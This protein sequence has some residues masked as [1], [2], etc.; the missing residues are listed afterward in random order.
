[1]NTQKNVVF[2]GK[3]HKNYFTNQ[4]VVQILSH[5][6][7][8]NPVG[9]IRARFYSIVT[10]ACPTS[11]T[12]Y[13]LYKKANAVSISL[14]SPRQ[15]RRSQN[16]N[17]SDI[18]SEL[19]SKRFNVPKLRRPALR[20]LSEGNTGIA[21]GGLSSKAKKT[22]KNNKTHNTKNNI[23]L[24]VRFETSNCDYRKKSSS[25]L[26]NPS[27]IR[28]NKRKSSQTRKTPP[29]KFDAR[30]TPPKKPPCSATGLMATLACLHIAT[31]PF[32]SDP[33]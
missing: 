1:M 9:D 17:T 28:N 20:T 4:D 23:A 25:N 12:S 18:R 10:S 24:P 13:K 5:L 22:W 16:N 6:K 19:L 31:K 26:S 8:V 7:K 27:Q 21:A 2:S 3:W 15:S 29:K 14:T 11:M 30:T 32:D 33:R